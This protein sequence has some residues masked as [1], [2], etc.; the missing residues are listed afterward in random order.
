V[1]AI[2][3]GNQGIETQRLEERREERARVE[4]RNT[5]NT[6]KEVQKKHASKREREREREKH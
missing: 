3:P 6:R 2:E 5:L 4:P 1:G